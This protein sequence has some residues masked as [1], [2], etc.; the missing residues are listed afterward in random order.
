MRTIRLLLLTLL[1]LA[2]PA[3]SFAQFGVAITIA[4]PAL[5]VYAQPMAPADGYIVDARLLVLRRRRLLLGA[6]Y[7]G[8]GSRSWFSLDARL[9]GLGWQRLFLE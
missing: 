9:L 7:V 5:P 3:A 4:P 1:I 8:D 6:G 2:I